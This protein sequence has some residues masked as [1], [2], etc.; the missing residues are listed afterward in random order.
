MSILDNSVLLAADK[1]TVQF[2]GLTAVNKVDFIIPRE[3]IV[4][5]IGPNG[6]GKTTFFNVLTGLYEPTSGS[7]IFDGEKSSATQPHLIAA[8]GIAR[9]FQNIRLFGAM[10]ASENVMVAMHPHLKANVFSTVFRTPRQRREERESKQ[11]AHE[12]LEFVGITG[13]DEEFA[14]NLPYGDQRR[15][16]VARALA[17]RPKLLLLDEPTAGMNPQESAAFTAFVHRVRDQLGVTILLIE[18]DMKVVMGTAERITVLEYGTK[19]AEGTPAEI[20]SNPK[21]IE[22]YLGK[23]ATEGAA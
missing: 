10:T 2:G 15:L 13:A 16:E 9:T 20:R 4:A 3:S 21:V 22:A 1:I 18:H 7:V 19:I 12:L 6:A 11:R 17:L 14:K 8:R 5:L 23:A